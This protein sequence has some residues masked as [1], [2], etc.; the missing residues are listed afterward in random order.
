[1]ETFEYF[2]PVIFFKCISVLHPQKIL[3]Q[4]T[5]ARFSNG[6]A[7][8]S[9]VVVHYLMDVIPGQEPWPVMIFKDQYYFG[10]RSTSVYGHPR[11][12]NLRERDRGSN[13]KGFSMGYMFQEGNWT[14]LS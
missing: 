13:R 2:A 7:N 11:F 10:Q 8:D 6:F 12:Q 5:S 14:R 4:S 1:M 9:G 3:M